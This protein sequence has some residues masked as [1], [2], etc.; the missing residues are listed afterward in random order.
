MT[1]EKEQVFRLED[2]NGDGV[3]DLSKLVVEDFHDE[4]TDVMGG[5]LSDGNDLYVTVAPDLWRLRDKNGDGIADEKS[6]FRMAMVFTLALADTACQGLK[7]ALM[8][9]FTGKLAT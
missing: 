2:T 8:D 1:I 3:A 6:L 5:V 7:W 4:V 9:G